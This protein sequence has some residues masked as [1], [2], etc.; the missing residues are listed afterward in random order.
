[1]FFYK[2]INPISCQFEKKRIQLNN[3]KRYI[4]VD[5]I[6]KDLELDEK[7]KSLENAIKY[8]KDRMLNS[9]DE[10]EKLLLLKGL[11]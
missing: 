6:K 2:N 1:M 9:L 5:D 7:D 3:I 8:T 11:M 4:T 10:E